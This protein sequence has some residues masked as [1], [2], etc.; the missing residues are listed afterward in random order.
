MRQGQ[1]RKTIS[2]SAV[3]PRSL[4]PWH[5]WSSTAVA[6]FFGTD[7]K[8]GL[9]TG[10]L[11]KALKRYGKNVI[12]RRGETRWYHRILRRLRDPLTAVLLAGAAISA[13][14]AEWADTAVIFIAIALDLSITLF[15]EH[16]A[17]QAL[18]ALAKRLVLRAN[19]IREGREK[20]VAAADLVPGDLV[21]LKRGEKVPADIRLM[22]AAGLR[23]SEAVLTGEAQEVT[24]Q[25]QP[26]PSATALADRSNML[27]AGTQVT[28]GEGIG[29]VVATGAR[30][31]FGRIAAAVKQVQ[32]PP[33]PL[34]RKLRHLAQTIGG[35]VLVAAA[36]IF[37]LGLLEGKSAM[38]MFRTAVALAVAA[39]P[40]DLTM[41]LAITFTVGAV[42]IARWQGIIRT[43][44]SAETLGSA[45]VICTDKTGTLT[46]G[47]MSVQ[48]FETLGFSL[49]PRALTR[50]IPAFLR[51]ALV[52]CAV[53]TD[54]REVETEKG[55][56]LAGSHTEQALLR[57]ALDAGLRQ[58]E[59][60]AFWSPLASLAF[61]AVRKYRAVLTNH[62][63]AAATKL[64]VIG[65]ADILLPQVTSLA[66]EGG[67]KLLR[68][69]ERKWFAEQI[70]KAAGEG[71]R[72]LLIASRDFPQSKRKLTQKDVAQLTLLTLVYLHDPVRPGVKQALELAAQAGVRTIMV[73]G[74]HRATAEAVARQIGLSVTTRSTITG[75]DL[76]KMDDETLLQRLPHT[77]IFAR[78][79]PFDKQRIINAL[80]AQNHVV[81]MTGDGVNDAIALK[82]ADIGIAVGSGTDVAKDAADLILLNDA[83]ETIVS[84]IKEGRVV[85]E[86]VKKVLTF[87][88]TTNLAEVATIIATLV[89]RLPI[90]FLPAHILWINLVTDGTADVALALEPAEPDIMQRPPERPERRLL[91]PRLILQMLLGAAILLTGTLFVFTRT[92]EG[93]NS[94][95]YA[96]SAAFA[97]LSLATLLSVF[98]YR[99]L[100]T[101]YLELHTRNRSVW[102]AEITSLAL[103]LAALYFPPLQ[104]LLGTEPL[105]WQTWV[106]LSVLAVICVIG[107]EARKLLSRPISF[108]AEEASEE[109]LALPG[110]Q[111]WSSFPAPA[112]RQK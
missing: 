59:L 33:T 66:A 84:A 58:K 69:R 72:V 90:A 24:K 18:A 76:Q 89:A 15:Q 82:E 19:V 7:V 55:P 9:T 46:A 30:T 93:E 49:T 22:R 101:P 3:L 53:C 75:E 40:E 8:K 103:L 32:P 39:V 70:E 81:A 56:R 74:D 100:K 6:E 99:S 65:A 87:L 64:F 102:L 47:K 112:K 80:H 52:A 26:L 21:R 67:T 60:F 106:W 27:Y 97:F 92:L 10:Q 107:I 20:I 23:V 37:L 63:T 104:R 36:G 13:V 86:N 78:V 109:N 68:S 38:D 71:L 25:S 16:R 29:I 108:N 57:L 110:E 31:V 79:T 28:A 91:T 11:R 96:R 44:S 17:A 83:Y 48:R 105:S 111:A 50:K 51:E 45:T 34:Q 35:L 1:T 88:L 41:I 42:R 94:L 98:S 62:P 2:T 73:T 61:D 5:A 43:L 12:D 4:R 54:A 14:L 95:A 85:T 77:T